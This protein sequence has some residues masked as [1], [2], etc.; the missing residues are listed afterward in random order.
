MN[1][2][3][4]P[5]NLKKADPKPTRGPNNYTQEIERKKN[6][7]QHINNKPPLVAAKIK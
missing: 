3:P 4:I 6:Q 7:K 2:E 5:L 1:N